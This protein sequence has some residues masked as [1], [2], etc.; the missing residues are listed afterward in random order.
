MDGKNN[1]KIFNKNMDSGV[2]K[3]FAKIK[4]GCFKM[5]IEVYENAK[6]LREEMDRLNAIKNS[7]S[8]HDAVL[9]ILNGYDVPIRVNDDI[10]N[11]LMTTIN[12]MIGS[13]EGQFENL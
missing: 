6:K 3:N 2:F 8:K 13:L 12:L 4:K 7:L 1:R 10:H 9:S 11:S 5:T